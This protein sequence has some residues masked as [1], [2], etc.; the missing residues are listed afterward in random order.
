M[1]KVGEIGNAVHATL[2]LLEFDDTPAVGITPSTSATAPVPKPRL[3]QAAR[4]ALHD[5]WIADR[6][7]LESQYEEFHAWFLKRNLE[8]LRDTQT[9]PEERAD[10]L[11]WIEEPAPSE[12]A[13]RA[14]S[15]VECCRC[16]DGRLDVEVMRE[17]L[18]VIHQ[19]VV[20]SA[21]RRVVDPP[22]VQRH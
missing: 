5:G 10:I 8:L 2:P 3:T 21:A 17:R 12:D 16:Y 4:K 20:A 14:F 13:A 15:F 19:R 7:Q 22:S 9:G 18:R 6:L 1:W 11:A